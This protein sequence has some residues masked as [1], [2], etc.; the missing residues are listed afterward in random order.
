M[1]KGENVVMLFHLI[2]LTSEEKSIVSKVHKDGS[3]TLENGFRFNAK[4][5]RCMN[6][7]TAFGASRSLKI[8]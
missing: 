6:D 5:G 8:K 7:N 2:G 4:T 3:I 1:K